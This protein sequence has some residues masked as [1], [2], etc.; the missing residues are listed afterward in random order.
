MTTDLEHFAALDQ[1][2]VAAVKGIK[3]LSA[4][5]WPARV[6]QDFL[7]HWQRGDARL[8]QVEYPKYELGACRAELDAISSE[9]D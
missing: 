1:R 3:L 6:Q 2:L 8:P 5:S 7:A 9:A 4:V